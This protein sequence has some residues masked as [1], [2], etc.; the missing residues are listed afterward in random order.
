M[1]GKRHLLTLF[2]GW[3]CDAACKGSA[4]GRASS[5]RK[6]AGSMLGPVAERGRSRC[7]WSAE[8]PVLTNVPLLCS[9]T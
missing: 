2:E 1:L 4:L 3:S 9:Q 8:P 6:A 7:S 5:Y